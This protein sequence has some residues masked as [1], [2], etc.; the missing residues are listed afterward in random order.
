MAD[1]RI[2]FDIPS[3][4]KKN[5][6]TPWL[7]PQKRTDVNPTIFD[8]EFLNACVDEAHHVRN[9]GARYWAFLGIR[10]RAVTMFAA[11]ATALHTA[12]R[13]ITSVGRLASIEK[14]M[15]KDVDED[16]R[17]DRRQISRL[18]RSRHK[19]TQNSS[20]QRFDDDV[21]LDDEVD[22]K[23]IEIQHNA[24]KRLK[25]CFEGRII[26][27]TTASKDYEGNPIIPLKPYV[28][29]NAVV[30]L[31]DWENEVIM[32]I[33]G[34]AEEGISDAN[35]M[36]QFYTRTFY[37]EYRVALGWAGGDDQRDHPERYFKSQDDWL[38]CPGTKIDAAV[39]ICAHLLSRD[40]AP[41]HLRR[42][43]WI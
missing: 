24:V 19:S 17:D 41:R 42:P 36:G 9:M 14:F 8:L 10:D 32:E 29:V 30:R 3:H 28:H 12:P 18:R 37:L 5:R 20:A 26:R 25:S 16:D 43:R 22:E 34:R 35:E 7:A 11:T 33:A 39:R 40:D 6:K 27:R 4:E 38:E 23:I 2:A 21:E 31:H 15:N 13:D 1:A